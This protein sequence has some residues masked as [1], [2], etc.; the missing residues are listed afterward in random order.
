MR[1]RLQGFV[2]LAHDVGYRLLEAALEAVEVGRHWSRWGSLDWGK[3][4]V[5]L[6]CSLAGWAALT[7]AGLRPC[8]CSR[9]GEQ[10]FEGLR[11]FLGSKS[12]GFLVPLHDASL[13]R[14]LG[15]TRPLVAQEAHWLLFEESIAGTQLCRDSQESGLHIVQI[16]CPAGGCTR[17][18]EAHVASKRHTTTQLICSP[19]ATSLLGPRTWPSSSA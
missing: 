15:S 7:G 16:A 18:A 1:Q 10:R 11:R 6:V 9:R 8:E 4:L 12:M 2:H 5:T 3:G 14:R 13:R 17:P 19:G